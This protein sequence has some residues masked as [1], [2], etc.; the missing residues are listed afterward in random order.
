MTPRH[1]IVYL[2]D[3]DDTLLDN[4]RV[5]AD[6]LDHIERD[7][8]PECRRQFHAIEEDLFIG[9]GY[10]DYLGALQEFRVK[11]PYE[12][13]LLSVGSFLVDYPFADRLYPGALAVLERLRS[14]GPTVI[15]SDGDVVFQPRK[16][17]RSGISTAVHG[18]VLIY[19]HKEQSL[20]DVERRYP[21]EHYVLLD[22]KLRILTAVKKAWGERVTTILVK[23]GKYANNS[24]I[25]ASLP[26][27]DVTVDGI[28]DLLDRDLRA[29]RPQ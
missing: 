13:H 19:I 5:R 25:M 20:A 4:D 16:V 14:H 18:D 27:A 2:V 29:V 9:L 28:G 21:A 22:D 10:R 26:A 23:Q 12:P 11:H 6:I 17:E 7:F 15:L 3:V 24:E 1:P 8:G